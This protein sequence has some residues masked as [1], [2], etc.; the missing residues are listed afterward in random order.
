MTCNDVFLATCAFLKLPR[1]KLLSNPKCCGFKSG[2]IDTPL[3]F[4][5]FQTSEGYN[6]VTECR[7]QRAV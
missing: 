5:V 1:K 7:G 3:N 4:I 6:K 2:N